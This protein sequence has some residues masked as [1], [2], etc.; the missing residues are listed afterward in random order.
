[1][2]QNVTEQAF[3]A[4]LREKLFSEFG[5]KLEDAS[6]QQIYRALA[7]LVRRHLSDKRNSFMAHTYG[8]NA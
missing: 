3:D 6:N 5:V 7:L 2:K 4:Q 1:M 8:T